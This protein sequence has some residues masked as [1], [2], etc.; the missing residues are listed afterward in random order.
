[1]DTNGHLNWW[2]SVLTQNNV[3]NVCLGW[4]V[5]GTAGERIK[6]QSFLLENCIWTRVTM[7]MR[8]TYFIECSLKYTCWL[9]MNFLLYYPLVIL[10]LSIE[11]D[12]IILTVRRSLSYLKNR[13]KDNTTSCGHCEDNVDTVRYLGQ[14]LG[15]TKCSMKHTHSVI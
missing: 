12:Y 14:C 1:M 8:S 4:A 10:F 9:K 11:W 2:T 7:C 6:I 13:D 15:H 5:G 3:H